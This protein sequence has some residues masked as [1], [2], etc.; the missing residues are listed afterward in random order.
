MDRSHTGHASETGLD[1]DVRSDTHYQFPVRRQE[2]G[3]VGL[4]GAVLLAEA[5]LH[6][7]PVQLWEEEAD[8]RSGAVIASATRWC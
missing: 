1:E 7:E 2:S 5:K 6:S 3:P 4:H 8:V